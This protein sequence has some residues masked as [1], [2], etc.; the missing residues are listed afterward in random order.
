MSSDP[1]AEGNQPPYTQPIRLVGGVNFT[2]WPDL[3]WSRGNSHVSALQA[4]FGEWHA[5][6]PVSVDAVLSEDRQGID[7]VARVPRGIPKHEWSLDLGDAL[8]NLRSAFDAV[9]WGMATFKDASP[10]NPRKVTFPICEEEKQW[11]EAVKTWVSEIH[12]EFQERLRIMQPF[13]YAAGG[14]SVLS[15]LHGLDIQDKHRDILTVSADL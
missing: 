5:S 3:K 12:P 9:A 6:A 14:L 7:L 15:M 1:P 10:T 4:K 11:N 8:H 13:T 2:T